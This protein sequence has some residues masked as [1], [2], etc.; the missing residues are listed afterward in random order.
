ME[1]TMGDAIVKLKTDNTLLEALERASAARLGP[2]ELLEQRVSFIYGSINSDS[3]V[4]RE[5]IKQ[6]LVEQEGGRTA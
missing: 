1:G 3:D 2:E 6:M 5:Q 4:T